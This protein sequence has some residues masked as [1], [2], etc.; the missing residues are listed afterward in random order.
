MH[1]MFLP[2][3][4]YAEFSGRSRR[5]EFW[6]FMLFQ[7]LL[8]TGLVFVLFGVIGAAAATGDAAGAGAAILGF[9]GFVL[10]F[11]ILWLVLL[12]PSLAVTVR[13]LHDTNRS[14][15][16]FG[17]YFLLNIGMNAMSGAMLATLGQTA[18]SPEEL[19]I[20]MGG[21]FGLF[22][23]VMFGYALVLLVF[24]FL[25]GTPGPNRYGPDPKGR[26]DA[27]NVFA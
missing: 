8:Y 15:W 10:V 3:K 16:W 20:A 18:R 2:L 23:L 21:A 19:M 22:G 12:V 25:D 26:A 14:G 5:L 7:V 4:R 9:A 1:W 11:F 13:R 17:V 27:G 24:F 6:M